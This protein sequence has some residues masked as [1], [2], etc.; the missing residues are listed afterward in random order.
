MN[1]SLCIIVIEHMLQCIVL[2]NSK[3]CFCRINKI[4]SLIC[5]STRAHCVLHTIYI[6]KWH[7]YIIIIIVIIITIQCMVTTKPAKN[8]LEINSVLLKMLS[9]FRMTETKT[10][11][12]DAMAIISTTNTTTAALNVNCVFL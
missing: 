6:Q 9:A 2:Y 10:T 11:D 3:L 4:R 1:F 8:R 12:A 7:H 5:F